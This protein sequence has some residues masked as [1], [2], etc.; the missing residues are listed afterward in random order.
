MS[1]ASM[2]RPIKFGLSENLD[3]PAMQNIFFT[4]KSLPKFDLP[5][6]ISSCTCKGCFMEKMAQ[7]HHLSTK[8]K[9]KWPYLYD[10]FQQVTHNKE[11]FYFILLSYLVGSQ[12]CVN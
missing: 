11:I 3:P 10:K 4:T 7:V 8:G 2:E 6:V 5:N 9:I 12:I 1:T